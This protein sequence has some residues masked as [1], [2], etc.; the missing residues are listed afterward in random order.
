MTTT[1]Q[2]ASAVNAQ[3]SALVEGSTSSVREAYIQ[4]QVEKEVKART[5]T[6][7]KAMDKL[8]SLQQEMRKIKPD[9]KV[10]Q[11]SQDSE[12]KEVR[13]QVETYA[14]DTLKKRDKLKEDIEKLDKAIT[15]YLSDEQQEQA[16]GE[17]K[18]GKSGAYKK[19]VEVLGKV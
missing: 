7:T 6:L 12:G 8:S 15:D 18:P 14:P 9:N 2:N 16:E 19:L 17:Q 13:T 10:I 3:I 5:E 11:L 4:A 1:L